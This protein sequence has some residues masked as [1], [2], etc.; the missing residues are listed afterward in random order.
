MIK[1]ATPFQGL[2][3]GPYFTVVRLSGDVS[4]GKFNNSYRQ[5]LEYCTG[6]T[7]SF[8]WCVSPDDSVC[9]AVAG[10]R[11]EIYI[12]NSYVRNSVGHYF[13]VCDVLYS[14]RGAVAFNKL[15]TELFQQRKRTTGHRRSFGGSVQ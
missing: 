1:T 13:N 4:I 12:F 5:F 9:L 15:M 6:A 10:T 14:G 8:F 7:Y 2:H 11:T 3:K